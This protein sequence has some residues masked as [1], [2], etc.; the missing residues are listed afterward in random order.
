MLASVLC[1]LPTLRASA[2]EGWGL[3]RDGAGRLYIADIPANTVWRLDQD[4]RLMAVHRDVHTHALMAGP[5]GRIYGTHLAD[6]SRRVW[7]MD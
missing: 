6:T 1:A 3:A 4:G 5:D 7:A 2:H